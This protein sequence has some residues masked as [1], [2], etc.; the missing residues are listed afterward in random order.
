MR[1]RKTEKGRKPPI[2]NGPVADPLA[3]HQRSVLV[4]VTRPGDRRM[5]QLLWRLE[6]KLFA[7][8]PLFKACPWVKQQSDPV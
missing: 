8:D 2:A 1:S 7:E 3:C 5:V 6:P 4:V